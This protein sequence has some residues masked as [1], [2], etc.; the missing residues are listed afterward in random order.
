MKRALLV[1]GRRAVTKI[2]IPLGGDGSRLVGELD[3]QGSLTGAD[4]SG[5][6][7]G[8]ERGADGDIAGC[9]CGTAGV[10]V[11]ECDRIGPGGGI[12][13]GG[14]RVVGSLGSVAPTPRGG[15]GGGM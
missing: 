15:N 13:M 2:P 7:G 5:G 4:R 11:G 10:G 6:E 1:G 8:D 14:G 12:G 3:G 9:R